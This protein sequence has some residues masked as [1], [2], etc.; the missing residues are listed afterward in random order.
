MKPLI[1]LSSPPGWRNKLKNS[2]PAAGTQRNQ[3][4]RM[5]QKRGKSVILIAGGSSQRMGSDKRTLELGGRSL[6]DHALELA[7]QLSDD[8]VI[9]ANDMIPAFEGYPVVPDLEPGAGPAVG[10]ISA[11]LHIQ[12]PDAVTLSVDMPFVT[13]ELIEQLIQKHRPNQV[14]FFTYRGR[15]QPFP[16]IYPARYADTM[17]EAFANNITSMKGLLNL[18]PAM[19]VPLR[20]QEK[21]LLLNINRMEDLEKARQFDTGKA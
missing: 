19:P 13:P 5:N 20:E 4:N 3:L 16:A 10:L 8:I 15:I 17:A 1:I 6:A 2:K 9:S 14:T 21:E 7:R 12:T 11:L 18:L